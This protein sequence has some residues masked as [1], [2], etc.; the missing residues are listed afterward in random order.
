[1]SQRI[2][3]ALAVC[4]ALA[5]GEAWRHATAADTPGLTGDEIQFLEPGADGRLWIGTL[6]GLGWHAK[7]AF[8]AFAGADGK[9]LKLS[10]WDV[11]EEGG[12]LWIGHGDGVL[13]RSAAGDRTFLKGN[14]VAPLLRV[15]DGR[16][17]AIAKNRGSEKNQFV[18]GSA[19]GWAP[20]AHPLAARVVD[21]L[22]ARDGTIWLTIDGDGLAAVTPGDD[23]AKA[24]T[25]A[26]RHLAGL[27]VTTLFEDKAGRLWAG[28]WGRGVACLEKGAWTTHLAKETGAIFAIR[29][30][31][32]GGI[33]VATAGGTVW[34]WD[35]GEA[36]NARLKGEDGISLL[37]T[38]AD[39]RVWLSSQSGGGLRCW[40]GK[41]WSASLA[42]DLPLR[43]L[44][45]AADGSLW[46]GGILDGVR[47]LAKP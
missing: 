24:L 16:L 2:L 1:M 44:V 7:G 46:V 39:G 40:D 12:R 29:E 13:L 10:A 34:S 11:L 47:W 41:A 33:W 20:V 14:T 21:G 9:A 18:A 22:A 43:A 19:E 5:G 35:D 8:A 45:E 28:T 32:K 6:S 17:W 38:T 37:A 4:S 15:G 23:V 25:A 30:D 36:W 31:A 27:N 42:S 26:K 3:L